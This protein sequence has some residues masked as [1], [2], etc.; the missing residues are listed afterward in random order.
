MR[1]V[2]I[3]GLVGVALA[4]G[5]GPA[6]GGGGD[7]QCVSD[8][9]CGD[10]QCQAD[11]FCSFPDAEC[12]S[13]QRYGEFARDGLAMQCVP[14]SGDAT[15]TSSG[16]QTSTTSSTTLALTSGADSSSGG[17]PDSSSGGSTGEPVDPDLLLWLQFDDPAQPLLDSSVHGW[18]LQ[19]DPCPATDAS[20]AQGSV[21]TFDGVATIATLPWDAVLDTDTWSVAL[22]MRYD[23]PGDTT[24]HTAIA[25][26]F[27]LASFQNTWELFFR[28]EDVDGAT[29]L[30]L[31]VGLATPPDPQLLSAVELRPR[32]RHAA[33]VYDGATVALYVDGALVD[34][35]EAPDLLVDANPVVIGGD[36]DDD[37]LVNPFTGALDDVR[38]Y[39]RALTLDEIAALAMPPG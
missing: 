13:G 1:V 4:L 19:C 32:W 12:E 28:D 6:C 34:V 11:G 25:R 16:G 20:D 17:D 18:S 9:Q 35:R 7:F 37:T 10:G 33:A 3:G 24:I 27:G 29:D 8:S 36:I 23:T 26:P 2:V 5:V 38:W 31:E 39:G 21:G 15:S 14:V 30:V 22:W